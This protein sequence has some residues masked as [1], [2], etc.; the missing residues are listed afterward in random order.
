MRGLETGS[1][2]CLVV[3]FVGFLFQ[4]LQVRTD[5][6]VSEIDEVTM[7]R[8]FNFN[9]PPATLS[10]QKSFRTE[11]MKHRLAI[12]RSLCNDN[13]SHYNFDVNESKALNS[14]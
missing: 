2:I 11:L 8:V 10:G 13:I 4:V 3:N 9:Q 7:I 1:S 6:H 14:N 12:R 5:K